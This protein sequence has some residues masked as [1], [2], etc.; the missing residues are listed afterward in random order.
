MVMGD[1]VLGVPNLWKSSLYS[2]LFNHY[3]FLYIIRMNRSREESAQS[4][5]SVSIMLSPPTLARILS[6]QS[7]TSL[8][9]P[10]P[11]HTVTPPQSVQ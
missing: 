5:Q 2:L 11:A 6:R 8:S 3:L 4:R 9:N 1:A 10:N 7:S